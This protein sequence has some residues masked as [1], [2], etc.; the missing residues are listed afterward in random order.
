MMSNNER[1]PFE[2]GDYVV[3]CPSARGQALEVMASAS[4]RLVPGKRYRIRAIQNECYLIVEG[5]DHPG[6]GLYW[7]EFQRSKR[8]RK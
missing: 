8:S 6:G 3:Y 4:Q 5:Y 1:C 2:I 7:T